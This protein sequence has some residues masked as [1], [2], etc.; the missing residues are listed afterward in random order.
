MLGCN[1]IHRSYRYSTVTGPTPSQKFAKVANDSPKCSK[2]GEWLA[3]TR[4]TATSN[5]KQSRRVP[6]VVSAGTRSVLCLFVSYFCLFL[7][8]VCYV[9]LFLFAMLS[10]VCLFVCLF[11]CLRRRCTVLP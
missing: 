6:G 1:S 10:C 4:A 7:I 5:K 8:F 11:V 3:A 2:K 9:I